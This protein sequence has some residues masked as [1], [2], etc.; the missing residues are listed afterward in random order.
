MHFLRSWLRSAQNRRGGLLLVAAC[1]LAAPAGARADAVS[2]ETRKFNI[3]VDGE[4]CGK[5]RL[6]IASHPDGREVVE[7]DA[8]LELKYFLYTFRYASKGVETWHSGR[9][10]QLDNASRY[11]GSK[12]AVTA[13]R[14]GQ[15]LVVQANG[16]QRKVRG[17][18][19]VTSYWR[20]PK[21]DLVGQ[22]IALLDADKGRTLTGK[23]QRVGKESLQLGGQA[24]A[25]TH[26]RLQGEVDVDLWYDAQSRLV[27]QNT[28][29]SGHKTQLELAEIAQ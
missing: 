1:W 7:G 21:S 24:Q 27:R 28:V 20:E 11:G 29:E 12:Y 9:L 26:Y 19:W 3:S 25:C 22:N 2:T 15:E 10:L 4:R 5:F 23:L 14:Q 6:T 16:E 13:R 8:A 18:V 17:D